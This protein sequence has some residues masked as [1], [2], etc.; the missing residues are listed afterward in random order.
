MEQSDAKPDINPG[1]LVAQEAAIKTAYI[2]IA[3]RAAPVF[4][5]FDV[6]IPLDTK[7]LNK[8]EDRLRTR[9]LGS[10]VEIT[11]R[12]GLVGYAIYSPSAAADDGINQ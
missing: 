10:F 2:H 5:S 9:F 3:K 4:G 11:Q 8:L 1:Q 12:D 7:L 6:G